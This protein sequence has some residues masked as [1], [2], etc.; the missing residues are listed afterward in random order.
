MITPSS[1]TNGH[2]IA[3]TGAVSGGSEPR[4]GLTL[5]VEYLEGT[6]WKIYDTV[7]ASPPSGRFTY[8]Y[9]FRRTTQSITYTFRVA[10]P[11]AG[12]S[13]YPFLSAASPPRS[14]HVTP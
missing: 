7:L 2:T 5:D 10:I 14:V 13:G 9:T 3:F 4:G 1:T 11:P 12:V 8:R 6:S